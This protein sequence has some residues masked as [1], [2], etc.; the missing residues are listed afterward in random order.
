M[1]TH[2]DTL[3][4]APNASDREIAVAYRTLVRRWHPDFA[5]AAGA[6]QMPEINRA[7]DTLGDAFRR[8][9]YDERM[10]LNPSKWRETASSAPHSADA[11]PQSSRTAAPAS[12][13]A[14]SASMKKSFPWGSNAA[15]MSGALFAFSLAIGLVSALA[16]RSG[17]GPALVPLLGAA[18]VSILFTFQTAP[19][20]WV[21][22]LL[23][24]SI[25]AWPVA[26]LATLATPWQ[27]AVAPPSYFVFVSLLGFSGVVLGTARRRSL[28]ASAN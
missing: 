11:Y 19:K 10:G 15:F 12:F 24:A 2:Y 20:W 16:F 6:E 9:A 22:V 5:G 7:H 4:I 27:D 14:G 3:G 23:G 26:L 25:L 8:L 21:K 13:T 1:P 28:A 17:V 18:L